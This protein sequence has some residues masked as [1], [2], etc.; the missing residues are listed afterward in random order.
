MTPEERRDKISELLAAKWKLQ[1]QYAKIRDEVR[2]R[3]PVH[4]PSSETA[5]YR[6]IRH[7]M[8]K[9]DKAIEEL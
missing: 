5:K 4:P 8:Q 1:S 3:W 7:K 6:K 2:T 9:L